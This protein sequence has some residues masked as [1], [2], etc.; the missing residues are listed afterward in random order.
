M[1]LGLGVGGWG[2]NEVWSVGGQGQRY[3]IAGNFGVHYFREMLEMAP[4]FIFFDS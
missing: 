1:V 3:C 2:L 4:K